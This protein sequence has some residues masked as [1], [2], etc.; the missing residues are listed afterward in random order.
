MN[1]SKKHS[2]H[3]QLLT[4]D[5]ITT[6]ELYDIIKMVS[7][8]MRKV[9]STRIVRPVAGAVLPASTIGRRAFLIAGARVWNALPSDVTSAPSL[10][11]FGRRL[12]TELFRR[13]YKLQRCLTVII[14]HSYSG[15]FSV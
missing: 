2:A 14:F 13:C 3:L 8:V 7:S 11:V 9:K 5:C 12:K 1:I 6:V 4:L 15:P 10:A